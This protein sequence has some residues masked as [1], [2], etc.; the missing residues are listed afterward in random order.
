MG[1]ESSAGSPLVHLH[2]DRLVD[3]KCNEQHP[4]DREQDRHRVEDVL[5]ALCKNAFRRQWP[6]VP[7]VHFANGTCAGRTPTDCS[8]PTWMCLA[9]RQRGCSPCS[10]RADGAPTATRSSA[11]AAS[12]TQLALRSGCSTLIYGRVSHTSQQSKQRLLQRYVLY[13]RHLPRVAGG[14]NVGI[15]AGRPRDVPAAANFV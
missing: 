9:H 3:R 13:R 1:S 14:R 8:M 4:Q 6:L 15:A 10:W 5:D 2:S 11:E 7:G 12:L